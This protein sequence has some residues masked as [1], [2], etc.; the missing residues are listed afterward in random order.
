MENGEVIVGEKNIDI[1]KH[2]GN[3]AI[4][5]AFLIGDAKLNPRAREAIENS[6]YIIIGPGD[7]YTSIVPNLLMKGMEE[8]FARSRAKVIYIC[9]IMTKHG[10]TTNFSVADFVE[11]IER[12]IGENVIDF[13]LV[14]NGAISEELREK[15]QSQ[16]GKIP[17][18]IRDYSHFTDKP[19]TIVERDLTSDV[20]FIRHDSMKL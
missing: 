14:N 13:V 3:L 17:V 9:N 16:E 7:L 12:Y 2:D 11:V 18:S 19:Y 1:P 8:A 5:E 10:E 20:D 4:R 15:Y 6:D